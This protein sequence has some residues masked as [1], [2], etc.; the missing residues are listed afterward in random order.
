MTEQV[1]QQPRY[2]RP[3]VMGQQAGLL[4]ILIALGALFTAKSPG[5]L[6]S[7]N[8][9]TLGRSLAIDIVIGFSQMV[10]LA[11][12]GMNLSVGSIGVCVVMAGG[13]FMQVAGLPIP[14]A[15]ALALALG[16]ALGWLNGVTIAKSGINSFVVTLASA[17]LFS[18]AMLIA[19][20]AAPLNALPRSVGA[21]GQ[22]RVGGGWVSPMLLVA[23]L[24]GVALAIFYRYS[25]IGR[26][27]LA[28]GANLR[29]TE[30]S[31]VPVG[32]RIIAAHAL[33]GVLAGVAG[34]LTVARVGAAMPAAGGQ[35]WLLPSFLGPVVGG[36]SLAGGFVS[37]GGTILGA[38]LVT[39]IRSGLLVMGIGNFWLDLFLGLFLLAAVLAQHYRGSVPWRRRS[40]EG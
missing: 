20:K 33:S 2:R 30:M 39:T 19:T 29:A 5:F 4:V 37:V 9:F 25:V 10:V 18:G 14:V 38:A 17:N 36:A 1:L 3:F 21:F 23:I 40:R 13:Y 34:L 16:G 24:I 35:D 12:G 6:S 7:F 27:S 31:G 26:Q 11:T 8:L 22:M 32:R 15:C 28:T